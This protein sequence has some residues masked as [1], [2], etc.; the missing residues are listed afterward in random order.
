M[1]SALPDSDGELREAIFGR[2]F[3]TTNLE[4]K[5]EEF[6]SVSRKWR[7]QL[8]A[9]I[10][11]LSERPDDVQLGAHVGRRIYVNTGVAASTP[12]PGGA[13]GGLAARQRKNADPVSASRPRYPGL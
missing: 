6:A 9:I 8:A 5:G 1:E 2:G 13:G 4:A 11:I 3:T 10:N 7:R 12:L